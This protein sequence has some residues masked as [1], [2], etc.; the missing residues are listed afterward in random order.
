[1][2][3]LFVTFE[4]ID[5]AGKTTQVKR[6][7]ARLTRLGLD[8]LTVREPGG[9]ELGE[10]IREIL[11][12]PGD[13]IDACAETCL[14]AAARAQ[15]VAEVIL[16]ALQA[17]RVL[18][19]DRFA[20]STIA[21]QGAGRGLPEEQIIE[22]NAL[23]TRRLRPDLTVLIDLP[24]EEALARA[25]SKARA[26][27]RMEMM[28]QAFFTRVRECYLRLA[29]LEPARFVVFDGRKTPA[30]LEAEIFQA[31]QEALERC[32]GTSGDKARL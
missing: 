1:M 9:T 7:A 25:R 14:Y 29:A 8:V 21:Y 26:H 28:D 24:V 22:L 18:L 11:Q 15:L 31:V 3:G 13:M 5:G 23:V 17:R 19:A 2:S 6:Q 4:G 20:D 10:A 16:P 32:I 30:E 12:N 27:D